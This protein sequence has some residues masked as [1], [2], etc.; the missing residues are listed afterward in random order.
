MT[1]NKKFIVTRNSEII[2]KLCAVNILPC[3]SNDD[4]EQYFINCDEA[5]SYL[6]DEDK[7][8]IAL[9]SMIMG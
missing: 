9:T 7:Q 4:G 8:H 1:A 2:E 3:C 5:L 6:S